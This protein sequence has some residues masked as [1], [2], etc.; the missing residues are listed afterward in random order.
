VTVFSMNDGQSVPALVGALAEEESL[1][2]KNRI[3]TGL[4]DKGWPI[5]AELTD[6]CKKALPPGF[7]LDGATVRRL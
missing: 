2:V 4:V 7:V 1:R 5:P 6:A 3:A